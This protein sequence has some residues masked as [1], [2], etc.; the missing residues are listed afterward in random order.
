MSIDGVLEEAADGFGGGF[1]GVGESVAVRG[2][3]CRPE[4]D[5]FGKL[6]SRADTSVAAG[7]EFPDVFKNQTPVGAGTPVEKIRD[8]LARKGAAGQVEERADLRGE[9]QAAPLG[10]GEIEWFD[11]E[12]VA[13]KNDFAAAG[14]VDGGG[15][16]AA[17]SRKDGGPP[18]AVAAQE[19]FG[20]AVAVEGD[21]YGF[22]FPAEGEVVVDFAVEDEDISRGLLAHGLIARFGEIENRQPGMADPDCAVRRCPMPLTIRPA[23]AELRD[24][25]GGIR[26]SRPWR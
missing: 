9:G 16:H 7:G 10:T 24:K 23:M 5:G 2:G 15:E 18:D 3:V 6:S 17:Q 14:L 22:E 25:A 20:V 21:A 1:W 8:S 11:A 4:A 19:G 26:K 13:D 12:A